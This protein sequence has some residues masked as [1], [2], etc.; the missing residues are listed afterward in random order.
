MLRNQSNKKN[1]P[2]IGKIALIPVLKH[3]PEKKNCLKEVN[4][5][6]M[7]RF[8]FSMKVTNERIPFVCYWI[9]VGIRIWLAEVFACAFRTEKCLFSIASLFISRISTH[10]HRFE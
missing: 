10:A 6:L 9:R 5:N 7:P 4:F 3:R 8:L 2:P 1:F